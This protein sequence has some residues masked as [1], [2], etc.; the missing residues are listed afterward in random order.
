MPRLCKARKLT[1]SDEA[2][3]RNGSPGAR[4]DIR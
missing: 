2:R 3:S 1:G 4:V